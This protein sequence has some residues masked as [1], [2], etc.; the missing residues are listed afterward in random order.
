MLC[1]NLIIKLNKASLESMKSA[2][3]NRIIK[4]IENP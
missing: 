2:D 4:F 1:K 3:L